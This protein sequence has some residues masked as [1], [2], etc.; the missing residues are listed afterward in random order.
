MMR[1]FRTTNAATIDD[2]QAD[3]RRRATELGATIP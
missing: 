2:T 3:L 1:Q